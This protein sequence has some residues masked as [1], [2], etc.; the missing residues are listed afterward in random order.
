MP[1][2]YI[3]KIARSLSGAILAA[4]P[5]LAHA[6]PLNGYPIPVE[7]NYEQRPLVCPIGSGGTFGWT[8]KLLVA[9]QLLPQGAAGAVLWQEQPPAVSV[10]LYWK[11]PIYNP[12]SDNYTTQL[13]A[14]SNRKPSPT[15]KIVATYPYPA[16]RGAPP[17][18]TSGAPTAGVSGGTTQAGNALTFNT[19]DSRAATSFKRDPIGYGVDIWAIRGGVPG[20]AVRLATYI[21][22]NSAG[23]GGGSNG[24]SGGAGQ[25]RANSTASH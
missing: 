12:V 19:R 4:C 18:S 2:S 11:H 17:M 16:S 10:V 21:F 15:V 23:A 13:Y 20:C 3:R 25:R 5:G 7:V 8:K 24:N 1:N 9:G 22:H 14:I 6:I